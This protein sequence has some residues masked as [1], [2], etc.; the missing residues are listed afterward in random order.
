MAENKSSRT[1]NWMMIVYPE[2][3]PENW[4]EVIDDLHIEWCCSPLHD[5]DVTP[6]GEPKKAHYHVILAFGSVQTFEQ[7]REISES[8]H[9]P[10]PERIKTLRGA[11]RYLAH[12]DNPDKAAYSKDE[13][14]TYGGMDIS[15]CLRSSEQDRR[16]VVRNMC[17]WVTDNGITEFWQLMQYA[18]DN[19]PDW[20]EALISNSAYIMDLYIKSW[21]NGGARSGV[22]Q[23]S[24]KED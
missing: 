3:A 18:M 9:Q 19:E 17:Q 21:R 15:D 14:V 12:M 8:I 16:N 11:V 5:K 4:R 24:G 23:N 6:T 22:K 1:R 13:I 10:I 20:W 2:S 7:V